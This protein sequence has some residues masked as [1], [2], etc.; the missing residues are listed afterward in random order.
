M[1]K[2]LFV[3]MLLIGYISQSVAIS[4]IS[5]KWGGLGNTVYFYEVVDGEL[6]QKASYSLAEDKKFAFALHLKE[7]AFYAIGTENKDLTRGKYFFYLKPDD[8]LYVDFLESGYT[9]VGKNTPENKQMKRWFDLLEPVSEMAMNLSVKTALKTHV[10]FFPLLENVEKGLK[11]WTTQKTKNAKFDKIFP[12]FM[13]YDLQM[14]A[15]SFLFAP[16]TVHPK[17]NEYPK[18]FADLTIKNATKSANMMAYPFGQRLLHNLALRETTERRKADPKL[19]VTDYTSLLADYLPEVGSELLK[20]EMLINYAKL[21]KTVEGLVDVQTKYGQYLTTDSQ[22][23]RFKLLIHSQAKN[24]KGDLAVDFKFRDASG[25][26]VAL[27]DFRGKVV[28]VDVWATWCGPCK[29]EIPY[30]KTLE[31]EYKDKNIVFIGV[32]TDREKDHAKWEQFLVDNEMEGIQLFAGDQAND[33]QGPYKI[34]TIPRFLLIDK[35]GRMISDKAPRP[36]SGE[37][38]VLLNSALGL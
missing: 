33:I 29:Q 34:N 3:L 22:K 10:D 4:T 15:L 16:R 25:K 27:S 32:S 21:M 31:K 37:I 18:Y 20:G 26:E 1:R 28:Y 35:E 5:G 12:E 9:L 30:L 23:E 2:T 38:R 19:K 17:E 8:N 36:S 7:E 13:V 6:K 11:D 24:S 14:N